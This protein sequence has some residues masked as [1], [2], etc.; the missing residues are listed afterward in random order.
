MSAH[1]AAD[2]IAEASRVS[3]DSAGE[4]ETTRFFGVRGWLA[5]GDRNGGKLPRY[6]MEQ[7]PRP[8]NVHGHLELREQS[9]ADQTGLTRE[10]GLP[11]HS[12]FYR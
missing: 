11:M 9:I 3:T 6:P 10:E 1:V 7:Q 2:V 5:P 12:R 8:W 4:P